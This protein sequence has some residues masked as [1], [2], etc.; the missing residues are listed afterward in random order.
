MTP[1]IDRHRLLAAL[2]TLPQI[3]RTVYLLSA[4]DDFDYAEIAVRLGLTIAEVE[5]QLADALILLGQALIGGT[6]AKRSA[7]R[8]DKAEEVAWAAPLA[9]ARPRFF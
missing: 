1:P 5:R 8:V 2:D 4:R 7:L 6:G 3:S 9:A